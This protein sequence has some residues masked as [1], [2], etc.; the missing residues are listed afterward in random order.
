MRSSLPPLCLLV[1]LGLSVLPGTLQA[2]DPELQPPTLRWLKAP[3]TL[4]VV[5][6]PAPGSHLAS[7]QPVEV[8]LD[9]GSYFRVR[10]SEAEVPE[11]GPLRIRVPRVAAQRS[12]GWALTVSGAVCNDAGSVCLPFSAATDVPRRG[13]LAQ[14]FTSRLPGAKTP[15]DASPRPKP[16][17]PRSAL[18]SP[19][20]WYSSTAAGGIEAAF[21]AAARRGDHLLI[22]FYARWCPPCERLREEFLEDPARR[23]GLAA[24]VLLKVDCD[25]ASSFD[26]KNRYR[27]RSYPTLLVVD[28]SGAELDRIEG[29]GGD[30]DLLADRLEG[31]Q[32]A[33]PLEAL[34]DD[35]SPVERARRLMAAGQAEEAWGLLSKSY[36]SVADALAQDREALLLALKIATV[37]SPDDVPSLALAAAEGSTRPGQAGGHAGRAI[38]ALEALGQLDEAKELR[39]DYRL[40]L[41]RALD[42]D[43]P[44]TV[45]R[46]RGDESLSGS[47]AATDSGQ[48]DDSSSAAYWLATWASDGDTARERMTEAAFRMSAAI[49]LGAGDAAPELPTVG[50][51]AR[52]LGVPDHLLGETMGPALIA[53][54]GRVHDLIFALVRAELPAVAEAVMRRM[55]VELP[56]DFTWHFKLGGF[57]ASEE[58]WEEATAALELALRHSYDDNRLRAARSLAEALEAQGQADKALAIVDQALTAAV[59]EQAEVRTHRY[60]KALQDLRDRLTAEEAN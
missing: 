14:K 17:L 27:V 19:G 33:A 20:D 50:E 42:A 24:F 7:A 6:K 4:A 57:F 21:A 60:R 59:P 48:L 25:E 9:D 18:P 51:G 26:L 56:E 47:F 5:I 36:A 3:G 23:D 55:A 13:P 32:A 38:G 40:R 16:E 45:A 41:T 10:W 54:A 43:V 44:V 34:P 2:E 15:D 31:L 8:V 1:V 53:Q 29:W 35:A 49:V 52:S 46:G 30:A 12:L 28:A 58:R 39:D 22:D 37:A 11:S